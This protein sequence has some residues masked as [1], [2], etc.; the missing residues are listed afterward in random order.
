M[1]SPAQHRVVRHHGHLCVPA[2]PGAGKTR[3]LSHRAGYLLTSNPNSR[4]AAVTFTKDASGELEA[5]ILSQC[6]HAKGRVDAG[7]FHSLAQRQL[8]AAGVRFQLADDY[9]AKQVF[10]RALGRLGNRFDPEDAWLT[11][12]WLKSSTRPPDA[13]IGFDAEIALLGI[14]QEMMRQAGKK[15]FQDLMLDAVSGMNNGTVPPM[16]VQFMLVDEAQDSDDV[17]LAWVQAH[18]AAGIHVSIVGDDD[19]SIFGFRHAA[20]Y[21]GMMR[22]VRWNDATIIPLDTSY[23]CAKSIMRA[24]AALIGR[25]E[26]RVAKSLRT[27]SDEEGSVTLV[28]GSSPADEAKQV[29]DAIAESQVPES[30]AVLSRTNHGFRHIEQALK[31]K[32]IVYHMPSGRSF[33]EEPGAVLL[34]GALKQLLDG[35]AG[36]LTGLLHAADNGTGALIGILE[37]H[38]HGPTSLFDAIEHVRSSAIPEMQEHYPLLDMCLE[39]SGLTRTPRVNGAIVGVATWIDEHVAPRVRRIKV[40]EVAEVLTNMEGVLQSRLMTLRKKEKDRV[41]VALMSLHGAK[42]LEWPRVWI[43]GCNQGTIPHRDAPAD[44]ERRLLYVGMTRAQH[45]LV[46]SRAQRDGR[47]TRQEVSRFLAEAGLT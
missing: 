17:Q 16:N 47:N 10:R 14:Y 8:I 3:V 31:A 43:I 24:A 7:T 35:D 18:A 19:Q 32:K 40:M 37:T 26:N 34:F 23:R 36:A 45:A 38:G 13:G 1:L 21:E 33:F 2:C 5:R 6:P 28:E 44:E 25:N 27:H 15:D 4:L 39:W 30:W 41:G 12:Q 9:I 11:V 46:L 22:F 20:G 42:G 29:A